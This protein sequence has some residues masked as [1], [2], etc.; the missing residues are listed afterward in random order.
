MKR[1]FNETNIKKALENLVN[2]Y[3]LTDKM[4]EMQI[5]DAWKKS[6]GPYII[7]HT[8]SILYQKG[9]LTVFMDSSVI[10]S[11]MHMARTAIVEK[12]NRELRQ[13]LVQ[14]IEFF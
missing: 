11:E 8:R 3:G 9:K 13:N 10:R 4:Q 1:P 7:K 12:L 2:A 14:T 5:K 6:M